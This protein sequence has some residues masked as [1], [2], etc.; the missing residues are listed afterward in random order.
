MKHTAIV[1]FL[2]CD[3]LSFYLAIASI[4]LAVIPSLAISEEGLSHEVDISGSSVQASVVLLFASITFVICAFSAA[5]I[6]IVPETHWKHEGLIIV[7][8]TMG[9]LVCLVALCLFSLR[10]LRLIKPKNKVIRKL[11]DAFY[12]LHRREKES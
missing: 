4:L 5:S 9:T 3:N 6:A 11:N 8:T 12:L 2:F 10:L 1:V 7:S